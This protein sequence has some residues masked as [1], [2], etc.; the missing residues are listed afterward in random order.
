VNTLRR[1]THLGVL[2]ARV[3]SGECNASVESGATDRNQEYVGTMQPLENPRRDIAPA[4]TGRWSPW[5][6]QRPHY[7]DRGRWA[8]DTPLP[9]RS[10]RQLPSVLLQQATAVA[11]TEV[12]IAAMGV[13]A[14][15]PTCLLRRGAL[16]RPEAEG[17]RRRDGAEQCHQQERL[18][19]EHPIETARQQHQ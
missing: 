3:D 17:Q 1:N 7:C 15:V 14:D 19:A 6:T 16:R 4:S 8:V 2:T 5:L 18:G 9:G 11:E 13:A 12:F 10:G